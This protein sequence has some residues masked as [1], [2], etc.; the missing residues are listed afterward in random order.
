MILDN[1]RIPEKTYIELCDLMGKEKADEYIKRNNY[2]YRALQTKILL[3]TLKN[4][5]KSNPILFTM[6]GIIII[7]LIINWIAKIRF[8]W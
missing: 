1:N 3:L 4:S 6:I 8:W 5:I 7:A 2:N